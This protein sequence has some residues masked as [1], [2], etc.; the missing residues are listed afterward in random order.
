MFS[1]IHNISLEYQYSAVSL[2]QSFCTIKAKKML[3]DFSDVKNIFWKH[4]WKKEWRKTDELYKKIKKLK[5]KKRMTSGRGQ[6]IF[7]AMI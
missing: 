7:I 4:Q 5:L 1:V 6:K 2:A 3:H